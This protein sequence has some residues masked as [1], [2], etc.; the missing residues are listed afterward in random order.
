VRACVCVCVCGLQ[1]FRNCVI[2]RSLS[3]Q[4]FG[5]GVRERGTQPENYY[6]KH[7][8][9]NRLPLTVSHGIEKEAPILENLLTTCFEECFLTKRQLLRIKTDRLGFEDHRVVKKCYS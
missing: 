8:V 7:A 9:T 3:L 5:E 2:Y 4:G 1:T 6:T